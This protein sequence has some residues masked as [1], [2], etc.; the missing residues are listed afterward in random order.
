M[1]GGSRSAAGRRQRGVRLS[2]AR[3]AEGLHPGIPTGLDESRIRLLSYPDTSVGFR[4]GQ[5][6][7]ARAQWPQRQLAVWVAGSIAPSSRRAIVSI[8]CRDCCPARA[9]PA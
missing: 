6:G 8:S 1:F 5:V 4:P 9:V 7:S 3:L 2:E